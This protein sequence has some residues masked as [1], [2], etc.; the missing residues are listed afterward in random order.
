[1]RKWK[2]FSAPHASPPLSC[3]TQRHCL[4]KGE[5]RSLRLKPSWAV[6][7]GLLP[8]ILFLIHPSV[9]CWELVCW[10]KQT[11]EQL[12]YGKLLRHALSPSDFSMLWESSR[13]FR[14]GRKYPLG[15]VYMA[16]SCRKRWPCCESVFMVPLL[17]WWIQMDSW[18][19]WVAKVLM[20][21]L[22]HCN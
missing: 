20:Y 12:I 13:L 4:F 19:L 3:Q 14:E 2:R 1:M 21:L 15:P 5:R 22:N 9:G 17:L 6:I 16:D 10:P 8:S 11:N 18:M 7:S